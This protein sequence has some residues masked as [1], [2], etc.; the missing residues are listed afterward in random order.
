M[1]VRRS[2]TAT[3][4]RSLRTWFPH[5]DPIPTGRSPGSRVERVLVRITF[6]RV[7][8]R[9]VVEGCSQDAELDSIT[10]A[11]AAPASM[12]SHLTG[13][14]FTHSRECV[15]LAVAAR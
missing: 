7:S 12:L 3:L 10:V 5:G 14:P 6:P 4:Y 8:S 13:F 9:A 11:G 1:H 2:P 15:H